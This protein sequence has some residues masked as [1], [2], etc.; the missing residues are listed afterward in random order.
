MAYIKHMEEVILNIP[1]REKI[2]SLKILRGSVMSVEP[3]LILYFLPLRRTVSL[4]GLCS[5][6][7]MLL[8]SSSW[9]APRQG[10]LE[11]WKEA[12]SVSRSN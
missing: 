9:M 12:Q 3:L 5:D 6:K 11:L 10:F 4:R 8:R 2:A 1:P 7:V